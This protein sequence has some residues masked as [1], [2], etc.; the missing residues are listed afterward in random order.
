MQPEVVTRWGRSRSHTAGLPTDPPAA[1]LFCRISWPPTIAQNFL[2]LFAR[3]EK[4]I[5]R[6]SDCVLERKTVYADRAIART[7]SG[8]QHTRSEF[9]RC[10]LCGRRA[11]SSRSSKAGSTKRGRIKMQPEG[12]CSVSA[13]AVPYRGLFSRSFP[14]AACLFY[15]VAADKQYFYRYSQQFEGTTRGKCGTRSLRSRNLFP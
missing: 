13:I 12:D 4:E 15:R 2:S 7:C 5:S 9:S 10:A 1:V 3:I 11:R 6:V 14:P 8:S